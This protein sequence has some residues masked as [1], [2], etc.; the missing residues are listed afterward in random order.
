MCFQ[1]WKVLSVKAPTFE[2]LKE[3]KIY[4]EGDTQIFPIKTL[5]VI[6]KVKTLMEKTGK[7]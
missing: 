3:L 2:L 7:P 5:R 6:K 1:G 4:F